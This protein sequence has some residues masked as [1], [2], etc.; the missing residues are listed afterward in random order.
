MKRLPRHI[1]PPL[2]FILT[3]QLGFG[4]LGCAGADIED[5]NGSARLMAT[6]ASGFRE[7]VREFE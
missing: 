4:T 6:A 2:S 5:T 7:G 1:A 3:I